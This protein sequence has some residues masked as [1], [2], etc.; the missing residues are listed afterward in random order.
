MIKQAFE[1]GFKNN[2]K[3]TIRIVFGENFAVT[4]K[5]K[6]NLNHYITIIDTE[7]NELVCNC[8]NIMYI[9]FYNMEE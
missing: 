6:S 7:G 3:K 9:K 8:N 5:L 1:E 2:E 4:G